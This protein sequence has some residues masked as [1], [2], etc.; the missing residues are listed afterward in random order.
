M[1]QQALQVIVFPRGQLSSSD[2]AKLTKHGI[3]AVE[4][5][6]P[7]SV[8][9]IVPGAS[10]VSPNDM[11]MSALWGLENSTLDGPRTSFV[12]ALYARMKKREE[13]K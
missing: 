7:K 11:M 9:T 1:D 4:A 6:D 5:D 3:V 10:M 12:S 2:K 13:S 8:V